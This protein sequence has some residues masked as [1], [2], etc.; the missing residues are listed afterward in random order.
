MKLGQIFTRDGIRYE[1]LGICR[2]RLRARVVGMKEVLYLH[3]LTA[4]VSV[5]GSRPSPED[6]RRQRDEARAAKERQREEARAARKRQREEERKRQREEARAARE[7]RREGARAARK[8]QREEER[9]RQREEA[10]VAREQ[11]RLREY[12]RLKAEAD[13]LVRTTPALRQLAMDYSSAPLDDDPPL[14]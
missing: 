10:R 5:P 14:A 9:K 4:V 13:E 6:A 7:R 3:A 11:I 12:E 8:R 1:C 2:G